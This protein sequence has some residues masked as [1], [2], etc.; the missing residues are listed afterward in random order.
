MIP[1]RLQF[2]GIRDYGPIEMNLENEN[3][4]ILI[5]G[6]NGAGKSTL[7]FCMGAVLRSSKVDVSGLKSQNLPEDQTWRAAI[8]FL[9]K[10]EGPSRI[11]GPLYIEFRLLCEQPPEKPI[12]LHYEIYDGDVMEHLERRQKYTSGDVNKNNFTAYQRALQ[13]KYKIHPDLYYLIWYQQEVNQFAV[14][15]PEERF[16]IFSEMHGIDKIQKDWEISLEVVKEAQ[17]SLGTATTQQKSYELE[18]S[19]AGSKKDRFE[20][21]RHRIQENGFQYALTTHE[22]HTQAEN[23]VKEMDDYIEARV[24]ELDELADEKHEIRVTLEQ[25]QGKRQHL[26]QEQMNAQTKLDVL[27]DQLNDKDKGTSEL[28]SQ[29]KALQTELKELTDAYHNLPYRE[30]ETKKKRDH[31]DG[32]VKYFRGKE[33]EYQEKIR[34]AHDAIE[35]NREEQSHTKAVIHQWE[36]NSKE[37]YAL[38]ERYTSSHTLAEDIAEQYDLIQSLQKQHDEKA[39]ALQM[40]QETLDMFE[41]NQIESQRQKEA[42][43]HL[44]QQ[45]I[46]A[47]PLRYFVE[48]K[49]TIKV[50]Q[51]QLFDAIKYTVFYDAS[52]CRPLNDLYYVSL[53]NLVPDRSMIELPE[54]GLQMRAGLSNSEQNQAARVLWWIEQFFSAKAPY[55]RGGYVVDNQGIRGPQEEQTYILSKKALEEQKQHLESQ[56]QVLSATVHA[57]DEEIREANETYQV[58]NA[59]VHK[60]K[61]AE[62]LLSSKA[63]QTYRINQLTELKKAFKQLQTDRELF[64]QKSKTYWEKAYHWE[65]ELKKR[66]ADL[67]VYEQ[68]GQQREKVDRLHQLEQALKNTKQETI[69][70]KNKRKQ[71]DDRLE[72]L[73]LDLRNSNRHVVDLEENFEKNE[74]GTSQVLRQKG[75]K[76]EEQIAMVN[77]AKTYKAELNELQH[78]IPEL[79]EAA[80]AQERDEIS[81]YEIQNR[82]NQAKVEFMNARNEKDID[83]NAVDNFNTLES[84]VA[85]KKDELQGAKNLLEENEERAIQNEKRLET[86][87]AMQVQK[88]NLLFEQYM[89]LFQFEGRVVYEKLM[90]K[91]DRPIF[92]LF[93]HVRKEGHRGKFED[94]SLK[95]RGG[96]VGKGVSGGEES[97]SSLLFALSLLQNLENKASFI[98]MDE[99]DS[100]LDE[101]RKAKVFEL[102]AKELQRK[103]IIISP[104]GHEDDYYNRFSKAFIVSHNPID[105]KST[106]KG[107]MMTKDKVNS[108]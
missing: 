102:Y 1:W 21:N 57:I 50:E 80:L 91:K 7:S 8:H 41:R 47:Y 103:L 33:H 13:Y 26:Q 96:R 30:A 31:A 17:E 54:W 56:I 101:T 4:H 40:K 107:L 15:A 95:A 79:V 105:L 27:A 90:N 77:Q 45:N 83:P 36:Q 60:V 51:E 53:K 38:L 46:Q 108:H 32:Q 43:H 11:D 29:V 6:P 23:N 44:K 63:E 72:D 28:D 52:T 22:L 42:I 62:A 9:F 93:I 74:R 19:I 94:V 73:V 71:T 18:L 76:E 58:W 84:E 82:Q 69:A 99:F 35:H 97:L 106:V 2:S 59:D 12:K 81:K 68:F 25:A 16:R 14:M 78:L 20:D 55:I 24:F 100:A 67:D 89:G 48:L 88:I 70:L 39:K 98:I 66:R 85:R 5:T 64:E 10:N 37:A 92:K 49:H 65:A 75:E 61:E 3:E 34:H 87:I 86:A 104:K